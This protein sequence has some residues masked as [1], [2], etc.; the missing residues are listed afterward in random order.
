MDVL[1]DVQ[2]ISKQA[3][4][5]F[6]QPGD[7]RRFAGEMGDTGLKVKEVTQCT[8][9]Y[10]GFKGIEI[11]R[12]KNMDLFPANISPRASQFQMM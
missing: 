1:S 2:R 7:E 4:R 9:A 10:E 5:Q 6:H 12:D 11:H 3:Q 8:R